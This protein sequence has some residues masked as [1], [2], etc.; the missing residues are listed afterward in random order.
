M[1]EPFKSMMVHKFRHI[2]WDW[3]GTLFDDAWLCVQ[4][5]N[6]L[7]TERDLQTITPGQ[8][9]QSFGFP[10]IDYYQRIGFTFNKES[11]ENINTAFISE[12]ER[13]RKECSLRPDARNALD[14]IFRAGINQS[15]LSAS[16]QA[17]LEKAIHQCGVCDYFQSIS[18]LDNHHAWGKLDIALNW[19]NKTELNPNEI[20]L[21]GDTIHDFEVAQGIEAACILI[22][23]GHQDVDR[24]ASCGARIIH[25]YSELIKTLSL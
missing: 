8:Y 17:H 19:M 9:E 10:V 18:G 7:L 25:D 11:F 2:I 23:S 20:L 12:Y 14:K 21:I 3:N 16:K 4:V 15:I 24:L 6:R 13:R 1:K 22:Y 5:V